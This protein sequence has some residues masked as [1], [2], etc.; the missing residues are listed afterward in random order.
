MSQPINQTPE[1]DWMEGIFR[2]VFRE[3]PT[4]PVAEWADEN[5]WFT[6]AMAAQATKYESS[7]TPWTKDWQDIVR[8]LDIHEAVA[9]KSSQS[10]FTE[11]CLNVVR[12]MPKNMP[13]N[14]GYL[15]P[16]DDKAK[17]VSKVRI[18]E[19]LRHCAEGQITANEHDFSNHSIILDTMVITVAGSGSNRPFRETW[20]RVAVLDEVEDHPLIE[21]QTSYQL[22]KSRFTTVEDF[23]L[24]VLGKP[25]M[26]GGPIHQAFCRGSQEEWNIRC[27]HCQSEIVLHWEN[28]R[29]AHCRDLAGGY[30]LEAV[31]HDTWYQAQCCG[32]RI[33][34][35]QKKELVSAG[36]WVPRKK[37]DRMK[38]DGKYIPPTPGVRSFHFS[39]VYSFFP[40]VSWGK[41]AIKWITATELS[42]SESDQDDFR[43]N[44]LG[45]PVAAKSM[46]VTSSV[47]E[48]LR[49][50]LVEE[51]PDGNGGFRREV[52]GVKYDLCYDEN[53]DMQ[54]HL[55]VDP[56]LLTVVADKQNEYLKYGVFAM[57]ADGQTW[58]VDRG[59]LWDEDEL[60]EY[61]RRPYYA[62]G[63]ERPLYIYGGAIDSRWK[64]KVVFEKCIEAQRLGWQLYPVRGSGMNNELK[65]KSYC[66]KQD[67]VKGGRITIYEFH[68]HTIKSDFYLGTVQKRAHPRF[69]LPS[70]VPADITQ[71]L[72]SEKL[73]DYQSGGRT[74]QRWHHD[75]SLGSNDYGDI[76]KIQMGVLRPLLQPI[77]AKLILAKKLTRPRK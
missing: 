70:P 41:L 67:W 28:F 25:Q 49:G 46:H 77:I 37:E 48:A 47:I 59:K 9:M 64:P 51:V 68:D 42:P 36:R 15:L 22:I 19:T 31:E 73:I 10:G 13:G 54:N 18:Q 3:S 55:P 50:G 29:Y 21:K 72:T 75:K 76:C 40:G 43:K 26:E 4:Q 45:L 53:G 8:D 1:W 6:E 57:Q 69:W 66:E 20:Y 2:N 16:D 35:S 24:F 56:I 12:W 38:L 33:N 58:L 62:P 30:D 17:M 32:G 39:D 71:E 63:S 34:E 5:V 61:R 74:L 11:G 60:I 14:A 65:G 23:T 52:L 7:L 44:H 27:P